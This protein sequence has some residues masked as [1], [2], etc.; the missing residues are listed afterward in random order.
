MH[1][2]AMP[3]GHRLEILIQRLGLSSDQK[4]VFD[5]F[6]ATIRAAQADLFEQNRPIFSDAWGEL[7]KPEP[8]VS[9][10]EQS[11]EQMGHNRQQFQT[12]VVPAL[13]RFLKT[14]TA[15]QRARL[16]ELVMDP[17]EPGGAVMRRSLSD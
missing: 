7:D 5:E 17:H 3:P 13:I 10:V 14:L 15:E 6:V 11:L 12:R 8:D 2:D 4:V 9:Q 16:R 1:H